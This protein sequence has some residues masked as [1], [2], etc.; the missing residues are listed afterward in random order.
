MMTSEILERYA[1][2]LIWGMTTARKKRF[3]KGDTVLIQYD[4]PALR[5]A[6]M[7]YAKLVERGMNVL[8][9]MN[10]TS[11]MEHSFYSRANSSQLVFI[12]PATGS[13]PAISTGAF[14]STPRNR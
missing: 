8:Q 6:E 5:L 13:C 4:V 1:D 3:K 12:P 11:A 9:R 10:L 7:L 2:V 14:I